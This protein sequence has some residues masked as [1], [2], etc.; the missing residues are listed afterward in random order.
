MG[1]G[2]SDQRKYNVGV[3]SEWHHRGTDYSVFLSL[4]RPGDLLE[5]EREGYQH[6]AVYIGDH[7]LSE[8]SE[9]EDFVTVLPCIVHRANPTDNPDN[10]S[11]FFTSSRSLSKGAHGIGDVVVEP[12]QDVWRES[13]ARINNSVDNTTQPFPGGQVVE[14][15]LG[16]V[17]GEDRQA[18]TPYNVVT[19]NCEH[20]VNWCRHGWAVSFQVARNTEKLMKLG[21]VAG[22]A[23]LSGPAR[24]LAMFGAA[25]MAGFHMLTEVRRSDPFSSFADTGS[26]IT[27][28]SDLTG[29]DTTTVREL[30]DLTVPDTATVSTGP[31]TATVS[32][33]LDLNSQPGERRAIVMSDGT[34]QEMVD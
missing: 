27:D 32:N 8:G 29:L 9:E 17:H 19:N 16:V 12:L 33:L 20:F 6:W 31:D 5:F 1:R 23:I 30:S 7:A 25:V 4:L 28:L 24:P 15:A 21:V 22:A 18:Y 13:G 14:R 26:T 11:S 34:D 10:M 3:I 2:A